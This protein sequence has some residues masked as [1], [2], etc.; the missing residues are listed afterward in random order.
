MSDPRRGGGEEMGRTIN[1]LAWGLWTEPSVAAGRVEGLRGEAA[2]VGFFSARG[3][4][5]P[6]LLR[7]QGP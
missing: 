5:S 7:A 2:A 4:P 6:F 3:F 1:P